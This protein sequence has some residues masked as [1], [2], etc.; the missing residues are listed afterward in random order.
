VWW[1][2]SEEALRQIAKVM[3]T[4]AGGGAGSKGARRGRVVE[5]GTNPDYDGP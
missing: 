4:D 1:W 3:R 5:R 2:A